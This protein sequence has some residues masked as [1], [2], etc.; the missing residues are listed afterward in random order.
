MKWR[1]FPIFFATASFNIGTRI[2]L[3][4]VGMIKSSRI[5]FTSTGFL[6]FLD[7]YFITI[8]ANWLDMAG[9]NSS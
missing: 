9:T 4:F 8:S 2:P 6:D 5:L 1:N 3:Q 7:Q